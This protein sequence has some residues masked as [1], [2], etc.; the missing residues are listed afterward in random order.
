MDNTKSTKIGINKIVDIRQSDKW[1]E[2]LKTLGW[3]SV[4][5]SNH[6][7]VEFRNTVFGKVA[8]I[9]RPSKLEKSDLKEIKQICKENRVGY[10]KIEPGVDQNIDLMRSLDY[11]QTKA[12]LTPTTT[13]Y[14]DLLKKEND[15]WND[16]SRSGKYSIK[17]AV[18]EGATVKFY[19]NPTDELLLKFLSLQAESAEKRNFA[20]LTIQ[21]LKNKRD[22]FTEECFIIFVYDKENNLCGGKL[23][24]AHNGIV[25]YM[26]GGT[27]EIGRNNKT[28][29]EL[30]W[31]AILY[32]KK[33]GFEL[34]D[35]E[36]K[37][38]ARIPHTTTKWGGFSHFKEKFGGIVVE[39]PLPRAKYYS[40]ML[41]F[42]AKRGFGNIF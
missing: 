31:Q 3:T 39:Y 13:I 8:K 21:D 33:Q 12:Y 38:D 35:L 16:I 41:G 40:K 7:N 5:T 23:Y 25:W 32:F 9:Q 4:R 29:Y 2:Y 15:L 6:T 17:R 22:I 26:H 20:K 36:G 19:K 10:L 18:R 1:A 27:S 11:L 34:L 14:I 24:L 28:G 42:L 30:Q 37:D